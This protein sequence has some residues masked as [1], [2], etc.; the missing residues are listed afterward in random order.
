MF[1]RQ[2]NSYQTDGKLRGW[3][4]CL[5]FWLG[6]HSVRLYKLMIKN[7]F[8]P[9]GLIPVLE[10]LLKTI[11][12]YIK[13]CFRQAFLRIFLGKMKGG[14]CGGRDRDRMIVQS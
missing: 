5:F 4:K 2:E 7:M 3:D 10:L 12:C 8:W 13:L 9:I 1:Q 11:Y 6:Y 14:E